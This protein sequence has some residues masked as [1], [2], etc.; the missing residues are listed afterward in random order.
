MTQKL[1]YKCSLEYY[2]Q[3][4]KGGNNPN[5]HELI[6]GYAKCGIP[7][8]WLLGKKIEQSTDIWYDLDKP[9]RFAWWKKPVTKDNILNDSIFMRY[10]E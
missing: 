6:N 3:Q 4:P 7:I 8:H 5:V 10:Q 9:W 1:V 2:S